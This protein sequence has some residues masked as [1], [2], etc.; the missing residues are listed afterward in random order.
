MNLP[1]PKQRRNHYQERRAHADGWDIEVSGITPHWDKALSPNF[2]Y[3]PTYAY[4]IVP[5]AN[6]WLPWY[7]ASDDDLAARPVDMTLK[8][9]VIWTDKD[10]NTS[11]AT[12]LAGVIYFGQ[13]QYPVTHYRPHKERKLVKTVKHYLLDNGEI[14]TEEV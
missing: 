14:E 7:P 13:E 11:Y 12:D 10:G 3:D 5:D 6:G 9:D 4:R 8:V 1:T 2:D